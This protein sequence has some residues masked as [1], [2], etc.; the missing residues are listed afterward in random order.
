MKDL[1]LLQK[2]VIPSGIA[3]LGLY[4]RTRYPEL[5]F[6]QPNELIFQKR[7]VEFKIDEH[8]AFNTFFGAFSLTTWMN[9]P[10]IKEIVISIQFSG[11]GIVTIWH[12]NGYE[13]PFYVMQTAIKGQ[14]QKIDLTIDLKKLSGK[15]GIIFPEITILSESFSIS[16]VF[17]FTT[18]KPTNNVRMALIMP[19]FNR[20]IYVKRNLEIIKNSTYDELDNKVSIFIIDNANSNSFD[21]IEYENVNIIK[22]RNFGGAGGFAR[23][24]LEVLDSQSNF[25]HV[26]FC[27]DDVLIEPEV[28]CRAFHLASFL[29]DKSI[30]PGGMMNY[31][32]RGRLHEIGAQVKGFDFSSVKPN[33]DLTTSSGVIFYDKLEY[34]TFYGWWFVVYPK[35][36]IENFLPAPFFVGW[37][38]VQQGL[39]LQGKVDI[40]TLTGIAVWHEEFTK[41]EVNW[42]WYYHIRNGL[43]VNFVYGKPPIFKE[44]LNIFK[45]LLTYRYERA[46]YLLAGIKDAMKGPEF[47][48]NLDP[49]IFHQD[50]VK[51]QKSK[52][53]NIRQDQMDMKDYNRFIKYSFIRKL[54]IILTLNGH[55]LPL[56]LM[57]KAETPLDH[58]WVLEP[59]HSFRIS[60]IFRCP[61][62]IYYEK[63]SNMGITCEIDSKRFFNLCNE[64]FLT[65]IEL[66][67]KQ[68]ILKFKWKKSFNGLIT[69]HFWKNYL[70]LK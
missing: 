26:L 43:I 5:W 65:I 68:Y 21:D 36:I 39:V 57:Y 9:K 32:D 24:I 54:F 18:Q 55:L 22:N 62:V 27:D 38:D 50:L 69:K 12:D 64:L 29:D 63:I 56:K 66:Y 60:A 14:N 47:I 25:T 70:G 42:R 17:Y 58:G 59:L 13:P 10:N 4:I 61:K 44:A 52:L 19:T 33:L 11:E 45:C 67:K 46:E 28:I 16:K 34:S 35:K 1:S 51:K 8:I 2:V 53:L 30:I 49:E 40:V 6:L 48:K 15:T 31:G 3:P 20:E 37:D 23:G 7:N 41:K